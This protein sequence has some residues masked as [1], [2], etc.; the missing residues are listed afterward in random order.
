[1]IGIIPMLSRDRGPCLEVYVT[2]LPY[3]VG[4]PPPRQPAD[5]TDGFP[6]RGATRSHATSRLVTYR[7]ATARWPG[8]TADQASTQVDTLGNPVIAG[9][10]L[11]A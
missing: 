2:V 10:G 11:G 7:Q 9:I 1:M 3:H 6:C 5:R 8:F 4:P